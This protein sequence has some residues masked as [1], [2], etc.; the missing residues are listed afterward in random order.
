MATNAVRIDLLL[1]EASQEALTKT[2][3]QLNQWQ[4]KGELV[5]FETQT[6]GDKILF[7][8]LRKKSAE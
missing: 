5:K 8:I 4:T 7:K 3:A 6:V 1:V 2:Q